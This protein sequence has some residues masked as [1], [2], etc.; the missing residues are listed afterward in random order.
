MTK[1]C[2]RRQL[3]CIILILSFSCV[4]LGEDSSSASGALLHSSGKVQVNAAPSQEVTTLFPGDSIDTTADSV[5]NIIAAGYSVL[6]M[7][8][9]SIKY[10]GNAV[11][12]VAGG[13]SVVTSQGMPVKAYGLTIVPAAQTETK[14][15]VVESEDNVIVAAR[16]GNLSVSDG[17]QSSTVKEG[18]QSSYKKRKAGGAALGPQAAHSLSGKTLAI[19]GGATGATVAGILIAESNKKK[20]CVSSSN[21]KRCKCTIDKHGNENCDES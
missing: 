13:V 9:T 20:K 12:L 6:V 16:E 14:F 18:Q 2:W 21:N 10:L 15:E 5:A 11:E 19:I 1:F 4:A 7:P 8:G 3:I 17:Q